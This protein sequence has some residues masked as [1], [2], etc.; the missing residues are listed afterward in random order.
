MTKPGGIR[1]LLMALTELAGNRSMEGGKVIALGG[2][3]HRQPRTGG[4]ARTV[5]RAA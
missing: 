4:P 3:R 5:R 2:G 1:D